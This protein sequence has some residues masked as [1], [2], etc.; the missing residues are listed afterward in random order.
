MSAH[1]L[2]GERR[3]LSERDYISL[4]DGAHQL[5]KARLIVVWD[6]LS[7]HSSKMG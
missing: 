3:S 6:R 7:T 1:R 4:L 2:Q 5:L